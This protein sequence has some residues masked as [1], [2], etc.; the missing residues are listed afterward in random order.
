MAAS[1]ARMAVA[2]AVALLLAAPPL[3]AAASCLHGT[4]LMPRQFSAPDY[5]YTRER[6]PLNWHGIRPEYAT[7][8]R[9]RNQSPINFLA[10]TP[11]VRTITSAAERPRIDYPPVKSAEFRNLATTVQVFLSSGTLEFGGAKWALRQYHFHTPS[12]HR[13]QDEYYPFEA[14]FVHERIG[15]APAGASKVLV[16]GFLMDFTGTSASSGGSGDPL[17]TALNRASAIAAPGAA[18]QI[19]PLNFGGL[20]AL[21]ARSAVY[22]Y[23]GSLTT[24]PCSEGVTWLV[25]ATPV[26]LEERSFNIAKKVIRYNSRVEQNAPGAPNII[27]VACA[28]LAK[29]P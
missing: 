3:P 27:E 20:A 29:L 21:V 22:N 15:T 24:P 14:H 18:T 6:G 16:L 11:G 10:N 4:R 5:S 9:G 28:S 2:A 12:E 26:K 25:V 17:Q 19:G 8:A 7:C 1:L 13:V 23:A